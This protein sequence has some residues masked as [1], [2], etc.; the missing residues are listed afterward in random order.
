M[1]EGRKTACK[2]L[3]VYLWLGK[4]RALQNTHTLAPLSLLAKDSLGSVLYH[5]RPNPALPQACLL[6]RSLLEREIQPLE[7]ECSQCASERTGTGSPRDNAPWRW[8]LA[9]PGRSFSSQQLAK[10]WHR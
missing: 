2:S 8:P 10:W 5:S 9:T 7:P 6:Q 1:Q 4:K 3:P